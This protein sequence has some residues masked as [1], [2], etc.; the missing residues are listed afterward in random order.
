MNS[1]TADYIAA[2]G[3]RRSRSRAQKDARQVRQRPGR[4]IGASAMAKARASIARRLTLRFVAEIGRE[5]A[6]HA[7]ARSRRAMTASHR[8]RSLRS[9]P[10]SM[11]S[12]MDCH[13]PRPCSGMAASLRVYSDDGPTR[14]RRKSPASNS[15]DKCV[16]TRD[17]GSSVISVSSVTLSSSCSANANSR[18]W[19]LSPSAPRRPTVCRRSDICV[20]MDL[21]IS[22]QMVARQHDGRV[23][24]CAHST[25]A[26]G[27]TIGCSE[28]SAR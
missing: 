22:A 25:S 3:R 6:G 24:E 4:Q 17:C 16:D 10:S 23:Y 28:R 18:R 20:N 1:S 9:M 11:R 5:P 7:A 21:W 14:R 27:P 8:A 15:R 12:R 2:L 26:R 19:L 13:S